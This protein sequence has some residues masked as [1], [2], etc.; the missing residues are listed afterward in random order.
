[1]LE[2]Q[3]KICVVTGSSS[4]IGFGIAEHLLKNGAEVYLSGRTPKHLDEAKEKLAAYGDKAHFDLL[5]MTD[6]RNVEAY[7]KRIGEE[8]GRID[9]A[10]ANAGGGTVTRFEEITWEMWEDIVGSN[11]YGAVAVLKGAVP[12]MKKQHEGH[13]LITAS[14]AGYSVNPYQSSYVATKHAVYGLAQSL[15]YELRA[16]GISVQ[17]ICPGFVRT[18]I[19]TRNGSSDEAIPPQSIT[20]EQAIDEIFAGIESGEVTINVCDE[21]R[22][23][24][25]ALRDDPAYCDNEMRNL[26]DFYSHQLS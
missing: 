8:K 10:F 5:E 12:F 18:P 20:V 14:L 19:F 6:Y 17:A 11:L 1:M 13:L 2:L 26:A 21:A 22:A 24:Y 23:Y 15:S 3:N 25:K 16:D 7:M 9:Y 4:G